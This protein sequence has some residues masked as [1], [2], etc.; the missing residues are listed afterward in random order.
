ME[1]NV[2]EAGTKTFHTLELPV[3]IH[4]MTRAIKKG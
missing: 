2:I 1:K 4:T 3:E